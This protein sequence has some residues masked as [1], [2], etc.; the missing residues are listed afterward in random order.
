MVRDWIDTFSLSDHYHSD[1][2]D[3]APETLEISYVG[4][5]KE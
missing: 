3:P 5:G 1:L 2:Y 4:S